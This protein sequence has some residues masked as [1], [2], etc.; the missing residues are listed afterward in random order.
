MSTEEGSSITRGQLAATLLA[1][2]LACRRG[3]IDEPGTDAAALVKFR[4]GQLWPILSHRSEV[5]T[6]A[7]EAP[8]DRIDAERL[9]WLEAQA[10]RVDEDGGWLGHYRLPLVNA[11]DHTPYREKNGGKF[12]FKS[13]RAAIDAARGARP[14]APSSEQAAQTSGA[15]REVW[16]ALGGFPHVPID[17]RTVVLLAKQIA[18][19]A[20]TVKEPLRALAQAPAAPEKP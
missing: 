2:E 19:L 8:Q 16:E 20:G 18:K 12:D 5:A 6:P 1:Y 9:D 11:W 4:V 17:L 3:E 7:P 13:L 14:S 10:Q 15:L